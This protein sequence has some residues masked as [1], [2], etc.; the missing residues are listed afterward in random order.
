M[1]LAWHVLLSEAD[2]DDVVPW[3]GGTVGDLAGPVLHVVRLDVH[4]AG[5]LDG[6]SQATVSCG[7]TATEL[8]VFIVFFPQAFSSFYTGLGRLSSAVVCTHALEQKGC[9]FDSQPTFVFYHF[10]ILAML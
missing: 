5:T 1:L 10:Y 2:G 9:G 4:L 7:P 8:A 6:Q 3:F